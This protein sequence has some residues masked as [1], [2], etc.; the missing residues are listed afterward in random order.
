MLG[1]TYSNTAL[2]SQ[3]QTSQWQLFSQSAGSG[4]CTSTAALSEIRRFRFRC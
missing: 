2:K 4:C 3:A 1:E